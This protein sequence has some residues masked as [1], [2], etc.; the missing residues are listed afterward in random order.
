M[1]ESP[2][3]RNNILTIHLKSISLGENQAI[4]HLPGLNF[5]RHILREKSKELLH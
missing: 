1:L 2:R 3:G 4:D 5:C